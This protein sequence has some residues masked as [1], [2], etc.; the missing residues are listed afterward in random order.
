[1]HKIIAI[2]FIISI[3]NCFGM[4]KKPTKRVNFFKKVLNLSS[5]SL[6]ERIIKEKASPSKVLILAA[7]DGNLE[8]IKLIDQKKLIKK[9][10]TLDFG[11][12]Y[13][14]Q[15]FESP[16]DQALMIAKAK[17]QSTRDIK[18]KKIIDYFL[19]KD[20]KLKIAYNKYLK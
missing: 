11:R 5:E 2:L 18:Y 20:H 13:F 15:Y 14:S 3:H 17:Y 6:K 9:D 16:F 19:Q 4:D 1:M 7:M 12:K 10:P 8:V